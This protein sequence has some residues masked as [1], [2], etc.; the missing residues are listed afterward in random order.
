MESSSFGRLIGVLVSPVKTFASIAERPTWLVA[1]LVV[2]ILS[3][4][5]AFMVV[6]KVDWEQ[7][8]RTQIENSPF[9]ENLTREQIDEQV[10]ASAKISPYFVYAA[11]G[12][13]AIGLLVLG[14]ACWGIFNL[15][16]GQS[17]FPRSMAVVSHGF[18]PMVVSALLSIPII[19]A[20]ARIEMEDIQ[21]DTIVKSNLAVFAPDGA[22]PALLKLLSKFDVFSIWVLVLFVLGFSR[23]TKVKTGVAAAIVL[24]L[25]L[26]FWVGVPVGMAA[27][28]GGGKG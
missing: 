12:F 15:A 19:L 5:S 18:M 11:P 8:A 1:F 25:W 4:I 23:V 13:L 2:V 7:V 14:L 26:V 22:G 6:P 24:A 16:G 17:T 20:T 9:T 27:V 28:F 21:A 3:S 10:A